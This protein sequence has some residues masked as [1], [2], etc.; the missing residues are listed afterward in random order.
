MARTADR[1][2]GSILARI[3]GRY[4]VMLVATLAGIAAFTS[5]DAAA[6]RTGGM[7]RMNLRQRTGGTLKGGAANL[8]SL[9]AAGRQLQNRMAGSQYAATVVGAVCRARGAGCL[10][11][12]LR[13]G[14]GE[15]DADDSPAQHA[16]ADAAEAEQNSKP[17]ARRGRPAG[18]GGRGGARSTSKRSASITQSTEAGSDQASPTTAAPVPAADPPPPVDEK[19]AVAVEAEPAIVVEAA[20]AE[21]TGAVAE[22]PAA[23]HQEAARV[24]EQPTEESVVAEHAVPLAADVATVGEVVVSGTYYGGVQSEAE[25]QQQQQE[26]VY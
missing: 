11:L 9:A 12:L 24:E 26:Q 21:E 15:E 14:A 6:L 2:R 16:N 8:L 10:S 13:G 17:K 3:T 25:Q 18:R 5:T 20:G 1:R 19:P 7:E 4:G 23:N 22:V